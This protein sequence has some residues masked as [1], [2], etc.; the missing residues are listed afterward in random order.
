VKRR[1]GF[2]QITRMTSSRVSDVFVKTSASARSLRSLWKSSIR[3]F[4]I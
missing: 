3:G 1:M 2:Q 4:A